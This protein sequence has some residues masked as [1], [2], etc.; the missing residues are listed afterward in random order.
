MKM[1]RRDNRQRHNNHKGREIGIIYPE[2]EELTCAI[3]GEIIDRTAESLSMPDSG[4]P[5]HFDCVIKEF[6]KTEELSDGEVIA[7]LGSG[8]FGIIKKNRQA[9]AGFEIHKKLDFENKET[10]GEWRKKLSYK[11]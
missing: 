2:K 10:I 8:N 5:A 3:C 11:L 1:R 6:E 4:E 7:Y 9:P